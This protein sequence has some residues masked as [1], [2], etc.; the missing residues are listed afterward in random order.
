MAKK[1]KGGLFVNIIRGS[2]WAGNDS[3]TKVLKYGSIV[4]PQ[5]WN[6]MKYAEKQKRLKGQVGMGDSVRRTQADLEAEYQQNRRDYYTNFVQPLERKMAADTVTDLT[7]DRQVISDRAMQDVGDAFTRARGAT[8]R[9]RERYGIQAR[10]EDERISNN[11]E[12][13]TKVN[14]SNQSVLDTRNRGVRRAAVM[15]NL[16]M[17][18]PGQSSAAMSAAGSAMANQYD[19]QALETSAGISGDTQRDVGLGGAVAS[20]FADGGEVNSDVNGDEEKLEPIKSL[21]ELLIGRRERVTGSQNLDEARQ[22]RELDEG[23]YADGGNVRGYGMGG[24][25][26]LET[27]DFVIPADVPIEAVIDILRDIDPE[28]AEQ[29]MA[30]GA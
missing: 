18:L 26:D 29:I 11:E 14:A 23:K 4:D 9:A 15:A 6:R 24:A 27:N 1:K 25:V 8:Q 28:F 10:P 21:R 2:P 7:G 3:S 5:A 22:L 17:G 12:A 20:M 16:G 30:E 19:F 13:R